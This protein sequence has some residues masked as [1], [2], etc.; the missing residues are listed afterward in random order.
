MAPS[1]YH[2]L[3]LLDF[4]FFN[5]IKISRGLAPP[6]FPK[7]EHFFVVFMVEFFL[8]IFDPQRYSVFV[9]DIY[10]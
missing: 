1:F 5:T 4:C 7:K 10:R 3:Y 8:R 2:E 6:V 9:I